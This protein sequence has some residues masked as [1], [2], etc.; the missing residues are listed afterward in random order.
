MGKREPPPRGKLLVSVALTASTVV[1]ACGSEPLPGNPKGSG[2]DDGAPTNPPP[3]GNPKGS[4]YVEP[5][6]SA[7]AAPTTSASAP[8]S[9][10]A[11]P[12][13]TPPPSTPQPVGKPKPTMPANPKGSLYDPGMQDALAA[14]ADDDEG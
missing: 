7:S 8:A 1:A 4:H 10:S 2:Y 14:R 5:E 13:A 11:P 12:T 3:P 6:P 9:A